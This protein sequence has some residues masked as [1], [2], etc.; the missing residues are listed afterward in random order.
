MLIDFYAPV[1][2]LER[3]GKWTF[4][5][6]IKIECADSWVWGE[7]KGVKGLYLHLSDAEVCFYF[8]LHSFV[9]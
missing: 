6:S 7:K 3:R 5:N 1:L 2:F 9:N 4:E 8:L